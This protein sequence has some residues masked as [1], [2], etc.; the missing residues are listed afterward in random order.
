MT[1]TVKQFLYKF[2]YI[3]FGVL[4]ESSH[5]PACNRMP[6]VYEINKYQQQTCALFTQ[7]HYNSTFVIPNTS[8]HDTGFFTQKQISFY[9]LYRQGYLSN[10]HHQTKSKPT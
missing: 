4:V 5:I 9:V 3:N 10:I 2:Y 6:E 8:H 7:A 1:V